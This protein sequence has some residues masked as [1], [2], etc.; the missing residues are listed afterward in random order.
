[1]I[2]STKTNFLVSNYAGILSILDFE[3]VAS[4]NPVTT[5]LVR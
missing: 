5:D 3:G 2:K 1:M 4:T